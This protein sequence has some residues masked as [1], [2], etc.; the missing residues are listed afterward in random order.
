MRVDPYKVSAVIGRTDRILA[1]TLL[2]DAMVNRR[3]IVVDL[4]TTIQ[5]SRKV[6][7]LFQALKGSGYRQERQILAVSG[8][9][10]VLG[11]LERFEK[12]VE[13][14]GT[15]WWTPIPVHNR[16]YEE[17][18]AVVNF[19]KLACDETRVLRRSG[20]IL[21]QGENSRDIE[22]AFIAERNRTWTETEIKEH[23]R[24]CHN[25]RERVEQRSSTNLAGTFPLRE[26][27]TSNHPS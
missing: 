9:Q 22:R 13:Q 2:M 26:N 6:G 27:S 5:G 20:E 23:E 18:P 24:R 3:N 15:G 8:R 11:A 4:S 14:T 21:Y 25:L 10:S 12:G 7:Y 19:W 17:L 16:S 1:A